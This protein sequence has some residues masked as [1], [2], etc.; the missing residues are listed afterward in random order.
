VSSEFMAITLGMFIK[1][2]FYISVFI[3]VLN[4]PALMLANLFSEKNHRKIDDIGSFK[5]ID[6]IKYLLCPLICSSIISW[7]IIG[8]VS[9]CLLTNDKIHDT[10]YGFS[11]LFSFQFIYILVSYAFLKRLPYIIVQQCLI[12]LLLPIV[13]R[14][15]GYHVTGFYSLLYY[16]LGI[17]I[18]I[19]IIHSFIV[20]LFINGIK[21]KNLLTLIMVLIIG[22]ALILIPTPASSWLAGIMFRVEAQIPNAKNPNKIS[23]CLKLSWTSDANHKTFED[24]ADKYGGLRILIEINGR[25]FIRGCKDISKTV[26]LVPVSNVIQIEGVPDS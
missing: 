21:N 23:S 25:Y 8:F 2:I 3:L 5:L 22:V 4:S 19:S 14:I 26:Y 11:L 20:F 24:E 10:I 1:I 16:P 18:V 12:L 17:T 7:I 6:V 13:D 15:I 9:S